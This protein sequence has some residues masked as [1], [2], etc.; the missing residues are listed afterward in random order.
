[1]TEIK[2]LYP[3]SDYVAYLNTLH[4]VSANNQSAITEL[5]IKSPFFARTMVEREVGQYII[6]DLEGNEPHILV[7]TG[8]AGDGKTGLL[9]QSLMFWKAIS[10]GSSLSLTDIITL[11]NGKE[12]RYIKDF[13]ELNPDE[14]TKSI[15]Q[16]KA[17]I[18]K[19]ISTFLVANTGPL[20]SSINRCFSESDSARLISAIDENDG[21]IHNYNSI[22]ISIINVATIDNSTFVRPFLTR[23]LSDGLWAG[24]HGCE[25]ASFCPIYNNCCIMT[26]SSSRVF[27]FIEKHYIFQQE[28]GHKL[29]IRQIVA[30]LSFTITGG[31]DCRNVRNTNSAKFT[32]LFTN[33]F[34]GYKGLNVNKLAMPMKAIG[35]TANSRYDQK[36]LRADE[37]LFINEDYKSVFTP[38]IAEMIETAGRLSRYSEAWQKAVKRAYM[39]LNI[40]TSESSRKAMLEDVF[41]SWFPRYLQLRGGEPVGSMDRELVQDALQMIFTDSIVGREKEIPVTMKRENGL[42]QS[43]QLVYDSISKKKIKVI[44]Q[45]AHDYSKTKRY[46]I[47]LSIDGNTI[48]TKLTLPLFD[49]FEEIRR[50][51]I[52]T[53]ID[54]M[55]SQGIDSLKA[56]IIALCEYD[57]SEIELLTLTNSGWESITAECDGNNWKVN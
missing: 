54:P 46:F 18:A 20:I 49:Y 37:V 35:D 6:S 9:F 23:V 4:N 16:A 12:I 22:P 1:M 42:T 13:S 2:K 5:G 17:D 39:F 43:V 29:T 55:L 50:G 28:H 45:P 36:R 33:T 38:V 3:N 53:D 11:P 10:D 34:F 19:G 32:Y 48:N 40:D 56:Q 41:S 26:Q 44:Q 8:H 30:H 51:A 57:R 27:D 14:R 31:L 47:Y 52:S 24:C 7:L 15:E 21:K 25:K